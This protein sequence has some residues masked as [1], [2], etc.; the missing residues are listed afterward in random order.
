M[1]SI[2]CLFL[3]LLVNVL[4]GETPVTPGK[5]WNPALVEENPSSPLEDS[6]DDV[7]QE[8]GQDSDEEAEEDD[9]LEEEV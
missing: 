8:D 3:L 4:Q 1:K 5:P 9:E 2:L 6:D 7:L